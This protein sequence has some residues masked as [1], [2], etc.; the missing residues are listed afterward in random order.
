MGMYLVILCVE[1]HGVLYFYFPKIV[2][3]EC[4][5]ILFGVKTRLLNCEHRE[6]LLNPESSYTIKS[7]DLCVYMCESP[8]EVEDVNKM[9][10]TTQPKLLDVLFLTKTIGL[11][12]CET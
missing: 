1:L 8:R 11:Q 4:Q 9:V 12:L 10:S 2:Y 7:D 5:V 6:I 3:T